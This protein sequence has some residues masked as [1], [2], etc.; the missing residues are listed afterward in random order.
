MKTKWSYFLAAALLAG[1]FLLQAGVPL[2][3]VLAG[4]GGAALFMRHKSRTA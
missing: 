3:A 1:F 2:Q 4:I